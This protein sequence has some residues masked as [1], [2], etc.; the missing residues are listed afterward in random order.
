MLQK[1]NFDQI[2]NVYSQ[3]CRYSEEEKRKL[4][5][6]GSRWSFEDEDISA[7]LLEKWIGDVVNNRVEPSYDSEKK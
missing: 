1:N 5:Y 6:E 2:V 3:G 7:E 4:L